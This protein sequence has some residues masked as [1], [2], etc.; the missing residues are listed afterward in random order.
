MRRGLFVASSISAA[1]AGC[2]PVTNAL[3]NNPAVH[4]TLGLGS[5]FSHFAIG[6]RGMARIYP[7]SAIMLDNYPVNSLPTPTSA[8]YSQLQ[9]DGFR[10]YRLPVSG[11]VDRPQTFSLRQLHAM[12]SIDQTTRHDCVEGWSVVGR[13]KGVLLGSLLALVKPSTK[14]RY[15]VFHSFDVDQQGTPFYGSIDLH[16]AD[17]PQTQLALYFNGQP[18][19]ADYGGPVRLRIPTQ[20]AY[21]STKWVRSIELVDSFKRIGAGSGGYWE[22]NG[23]EW[24]AGI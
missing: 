8:M 18:V 12:A 16:Q 4:R 24:Y 10:N 20:L 9:R 2:A 21:K 3:N 15:V 5:R 17:H 11:L 14:A 6:T 23:Y 7:H 22:D 19:P 1:L 13:W